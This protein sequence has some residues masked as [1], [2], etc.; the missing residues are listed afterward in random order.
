MT[1]TLGACSLEAYSLGANNL[2]LPIL[3]QVKHSRVRPNMPL[4]GL[5]AYS[6][7]ANRLHLPISGQV[8]HSPIRKKSYRGPLNVNVA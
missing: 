6:L 2:H 7:G 1:Y 3:G 4:I 8:K 5:G